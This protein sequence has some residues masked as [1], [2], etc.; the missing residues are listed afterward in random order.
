MGQSFKEHLLGVKLVKRL[1]I[2]GMDNCNTVIAFGF[3]WSW[4]LK[5]KSAAKL[6]TSYETPI[7]LWVCLNVAG[8]R[9]HGCGCG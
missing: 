6:F 3:R 7:Q 5:S 1:E 9:G 4:K 8:G 2:F